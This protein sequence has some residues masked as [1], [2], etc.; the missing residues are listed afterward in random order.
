MK[1]AFSVVFTILICSL[2]SF[3]QQHVRGTVYES[4]LGDKLDSVLVEVDGMDIC[5]LTDTAGHYKITVPNGKVFLL[6]SKKGYDRLYEKV[7]KSYEIDVVLASLTTETQN[8]NVGYGS[9]RSTEITGA[10]TSIGSGG[11][12]PRSYVSSTKQLKK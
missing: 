4:E 9:Q 1:R 3:S 5:S 6:F 8:V 2:T 12:R 11:V 10:V 7:R